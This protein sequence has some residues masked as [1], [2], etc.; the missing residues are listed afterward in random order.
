MKLALASLSRLV[1]VPVVVAMLL[2]I[3]PISSSSA[4][5]ASSPWTP[6]WVQNFA[7]THL[8]SGSG[9]AAVDYGALP[10]WSYLQWVAPQNG[11]RLYV[12]VPWTKNY[13]YVDATAVGPSGPP[14]AGWVGQTLPPDATPSGS[15]AQ[16]VQA[17]Q[18][19]PVS[20]DGPD[21]VGR[22][23]GSEL[24]VRSAPSLSA[25]ILRDLPTGAI[26]HVSGWV[27]G[28]EV[29]PGDW[30][31]AQL[32]DGGYSYT[33]ALQIIPPKAVPPPPANHP[34]GRWV[35]VNRLHQTAVA[36]E[37]DTPVHLAIVST[38]SPGWETPVGTF[39]IQRRVANETMTGASLNNLGL[40]AWHSA[41]ATYD[42]KG[43]LDTQYFDD[44]GD[45]LHDN[46]WLPASRFGVPH[47][48]G[49]VG[50][51]LADANWFWNWADVGVP[52]VIH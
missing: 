30:T 32:S 50:M 45:A 47:S 8:W 29:V 49:C 36:Y 9:G 37:G 44:S 1:L 19:T 52:V 6:R 26:V 18:V 2:A 20:G 17:T 34:S 51:Q 31:W 3:I 7:P 12:Y 28:D 5:A 4:S 14:P 42:L 48:H 22:V 23:I 27:Q 11:P 46:Y 25:A 40:D 43:V 16:V 10:Q 39:A 38:G 24:I 21:W 35:D 41:H 33:E 15:P 13:A